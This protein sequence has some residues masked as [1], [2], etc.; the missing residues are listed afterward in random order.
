[1]GIAR[2]ASTS[3]SKNKKKVKQMRLKGLIDIDNQFNYEKSIISSRISFNN[4]FMFMLEVEKIDFDKED[5]IFYSDLDSDRNLIQIHN[6]Y[7]TERLR[8]NI[9]FKITRLYR[10][11]DFFILN[12]SDERTI[13]KFKK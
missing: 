12:I 1:M 13:S 11:I 3:K 8:K 9:L 6:N 2:R 10:S 7:N 4:Q 5:Q